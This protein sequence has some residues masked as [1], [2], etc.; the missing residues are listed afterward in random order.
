MVLQQESLTG[1]QE[2]SALLCS[3]TY[4]SSSH[5]CQKELHEYL[6]PGKLRW[7]H[8]ES[9]YRKFKSTGLENWQRHCRQTTQGLHGSSRTG[10]NQMSTSQL[11]G[12]CQYTTDEHPLIRN[13]PLTLDIWTTWISISFLMLPAGQEEGENSVCKTLWRSQCKEK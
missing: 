4:R 10:I 1:K 5:R 11:K 8:V 3:R 6:L 9:N 12:T 2:R 13:T 7:E